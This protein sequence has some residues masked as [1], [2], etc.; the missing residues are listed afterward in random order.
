VLEANNT[1]P[2]NPSVSLLTSATGNPADSIGNYVLTGEY[3]GFSIAGDYSCT[4]G[5]QV[6]LYARGGNS[7]GSGANAAIGLMTML[8]ACP[9]S[10][11][12]ASAAPFVFVNAVST[13][14]AAYAMAG[15]AT[16]ATHVSSTGALSPVTGSVRA[17]DLASI[18]TGFA[19]TTLP[20]D[21]NRKVPRSKIHTLANILS[22]CINASGPTSASCTIL[23]ANARSGGDAGT[24]PTDTATAVLNIA[25]H[26][27]AN[28][29]ALY[30]LQLNSGAPFAPNL[31]SP[32]DDF[33]IKLDTEGLDSNAQN[34]LR[35]S[36]S[37]SLSLSDKSAPK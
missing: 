33:T 18:T 21:R 2:A 1:S 13:V 35:N 14:A 36:I 31:G 37:A 17:G 26:P 30:A 24:M 22:A 11:T 29:S 27:Q 5:R 4:P 25:H 15:F 28:V 8:G 32:P 3:G 6:Y 16:D 19:N 10:G 34:V 20:A 7:G 12:F 23:F 9:A